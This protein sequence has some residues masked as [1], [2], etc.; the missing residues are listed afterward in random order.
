MTRRKPKTNQKKKTTD[1][2][3]IFRRSK[4]WKTFREK[5]RKKQ[6]IDPIT[7]SPLQ[8]NANCHH[9]DENPANYTDITDDSKF[10]MLNQRSHE[11]LHWAWG[12]GNKRYNWK[13]RLEKLAELCKWMDELNGGTN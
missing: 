12:D 3:V 6:K 4:E 8:K 11:V 2:K 1:P 10:I 7:G 5:L 9:G 13:E